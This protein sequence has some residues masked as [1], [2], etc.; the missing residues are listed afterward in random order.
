MIQINN[1]NTWLYE[2]LVYA[3]VLINHCWTW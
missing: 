2:L 3:T 1:A